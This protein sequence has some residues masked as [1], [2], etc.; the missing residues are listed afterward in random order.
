MKVVQKISVLLF[1]CVLIS[2]TPDDHLGP[3]INMN[4]KS[5]STIEVSPF[6][7]PVEFTEQ[8]PDQLAVVTNYKNSFIEGI[9]VRLYQSSEDL[10]QKR[11]FVFEGV[12]NKSGFVYFKEVEKGKKY[13]VEAFSLNGCINNYF[14]LTVGKMK[15]STITTLNEY[16][17]SS[18]LLTLHLIKT[19][20]INLINDS[21]KN[22]IINYEGEEQYKLNMND[23]FLFDFFPIENKGLLNIKTEEGYEYEIPNIDSGSC[24]SVTSYNIQ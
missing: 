14:D 6:T 19:A 24:D 1:L 4:S 15:N 2:C 10:V 9:H 5:N 8:S 22:L 23:E 21:G 7:T 18:N 11:N 16:N 17:G 13:F 3:E 20:K 12:T